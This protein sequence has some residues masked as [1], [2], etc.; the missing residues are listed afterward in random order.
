MG[1]DKMRITILTTADFPYGYGGESFIRQ[2]ALGLYSANRDVE[3]VRYWGDKRGNKNDTPIIRSEYLFRKPFNGNLLKFFDLLIKIVYI[4]FFL[5]KRKQKNKD[6]FI[7]LFGVDY[8]YFLIPFI[9]W[10][11]LFGVK[12][13]RIIADYYTIQ[14]TSYKGWL[15]L[16]KVFFLNLQFRFFDKYLNGIVVFSSFLKKL[17]LKSGVKENRVLLLPHFIDLQNQESINEMSDCIRIGFCGQPNL[18]N[19]I[20]ELV[21]AYLIIISQKSNVELLIIGKISPSIKQMIEELKNGTNASIHYTGQLLKNDVVKH[22]AKCHILVNPR[23]ASI[24]ADSGFPTKLGDY[25]AAKKP[26]VATKLGDLSTYFTDKKELVF[27]EPDNPESI[28]SGITFLIDNPADASC[29]G[30]NGYDWA[31][32]NLDYVKNANKLI[33]FICSYKQLNN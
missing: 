31:C 29:I 3:V 16:P 28:A 5:A 1:R 19:G 33:E 13:F 2:M 11:K 8:A 17:V 7:L 25:F 20:I 9:F 32:Q 24:W 4:P 30:K 26:V 27:A 18:K 23:K 14:E 21:K 22:L 6:H 10:S 15:Q 12:V